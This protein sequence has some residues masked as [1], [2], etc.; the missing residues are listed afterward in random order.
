[1]TVLHDELVT[2]M[3]LLGRGSTGA[4]DRTALRPAPR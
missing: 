2:T 4:L 3:T 1:L